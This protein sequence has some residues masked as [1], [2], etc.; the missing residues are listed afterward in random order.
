[1]ASAHPSAQEV[2]R[3]LVVGERFS[4]GTSQ[5]VRVRQSF[6][7][8]PIPMRCRFRDSLVLGWALPLE[9]LQPLVPRGLILDTY[10]DSWGF[11]AVALVETEQLRPTAVPA[12][13][14]RDY[15]LTGYRI[16][17]R[18]T[19]AS[20][21]TRRGLHILRSD[22][23]RRSMKYGGNLLTHYNYRRA[24]I[25]FTRGDHLLRVAIKTPDSEADLDVTADLDGPAVLPVG[26][27]FRTPFDARRY[28]GPL[29]WTF[30]YEASTDSIVMIHARRTQWH[31]TPVHV[32]VITATFFDDPRFSG[33]TPVLANAFHVS[34]V[35]YAW[36]RGVRVPLEVVTR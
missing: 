23:N 29:P 7:R 1:M 25:E 3:D 5:I 12:W 26:S 8:H 27:P 4:N 28:A 32:E 22:T 30:D 24:T 18:H 20:G 13:L 19:D 11:V 34:D 14:G 9:T 33:A 21:R 17:V 35:D 10:D 36:E 2:R 16:F 15:L 6:Q 31:P